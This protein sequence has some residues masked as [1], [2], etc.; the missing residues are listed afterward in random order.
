MIKC[1]DE[2]TARTVEMFDRISRA[3]TS[4][5]SQLKITFNFILNPDL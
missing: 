5:D 4:Q 1:G 2:E 3:A